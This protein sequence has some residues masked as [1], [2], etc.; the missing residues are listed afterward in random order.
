MNVDVQAGVG[1]QLVEGLGHGRHVLVGAG[2]G[3]AEG[4]HDHDR[5]LVHPFQ[6]RGRVHG[7]AAMR[8]RDLAHFDVPVAG[9]LVPY[10]LHRAAHHVRPVRRLAFGPPPGPPPPLGRHARQHAGLRGSDGRGAHGVGRL[11]RVPQVGQHVHAAPLDLSG[12]RVLVLVD[13]VLVDRQRHQGKKLGLRPR[14]AERGQ[15]LAGVA[16]EHQLVRHH[17]ERVPRQR[18]VPGE[19]VLGDRPGQVAPAENRV[20]H[21]LTDGVTLVQRHGWHLPGRNRVA[22]ARSPIPAAWR[23]PSSRTWGGPPMKRWPPRP[24]LASPVADDFRRAGWPPR[25]SGAARWRPAPLAASRPPLTCRR[26]AASAVRSGGLRVAAGVAICGPR[27]P[28]DAK[29]PPASR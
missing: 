27:V 22:S 12:L 2:V 16:I 13:H 20:L 11:G 23:R 28:E 29:P 3:D 4:R 24:V 26:V 1:L 6:H 25:R 15:V 19:P 7:V 14:L 10:H 5:V 8:H 9:E 18:L 21:L 17:L